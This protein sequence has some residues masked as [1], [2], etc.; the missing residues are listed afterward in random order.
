ME[1]DIK[2]KYNEAFNPI[3][4]KKKK[5]VIC[6]FP[7]I[8]NTKGPSVSANEMCYTDFYIRYE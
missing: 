1:I 7:P 8:V 4:W 6:N 3:D 2:K 5:C